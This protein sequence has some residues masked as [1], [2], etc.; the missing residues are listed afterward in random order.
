MPKMPTSRLSVMDEN[1]SLESFYRNVAFLSIAA[2]AVHVSSRYDSHSDS[3]AG[4]LGW[5]MPTILAGLILISLLFYA[6]SDTQFFTLTTIHTES[7]RKEKKVRTSS[8]PAREDRHFFY[9]QVVALTCGLGG[10]IDLVYGW[11]SVCHGVWD[12]FAEDEPGLLLFIVT[13]CTAILG[14]LLLLAWAPILIF[15]DAGRSFDDDS[16]SKGSENGDAGLG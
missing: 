7:G 11:Y 16:S 13:L 3:F 2:V 5:A 6:T 4:W 15:L 10:S 9:V 14:L 1:P 12:Q 8:D